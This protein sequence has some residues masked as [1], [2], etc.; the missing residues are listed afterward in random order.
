MRSKFTFLFDGG[1]PLC[2][3]EVNFL[4]RRDIN[5]LILFV[6][7]NDNEYNPD[8]FLGVTYEQA[9]KNLHGIE[10]NG[11]LI[12]GIEVLSQAYNLVGLGWVYYPIKIPFIS[13]LIGT[14]YKYWAKYRLQITGREDLNKLCQ[15]KCQEIL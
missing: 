3:R 11:E 10:D 9:M 2:L 12:T 13:S 4:K 14:L 7:I 6:D 15:S 1:C 8:N 5:N